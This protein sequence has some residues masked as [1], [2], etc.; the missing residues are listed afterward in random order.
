MRQGHVLASLPKSRN[1]HYKSCWIFWYLNRY[2]LKLTAVSFDFDRIISMR[3]WDLLYH[4]NV[5]T[6]AEIAKEVLDS[7]QAP[8]LHSP[9][10]LPSEEQR[11]W[12][13]YVHEESPFLLLQIK[14]Y[15]NSTLNS[16][17]QRT[18]QTKKM[19]ATISKTPTIHQDN[20][21]MHFTPL[22]CH[23]DN[24]V[25]PC[26]QPHHCS[27]QSVQWLHSPCR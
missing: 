12:W 26:R 25:L 4:G 3:L 7:F 21:Q 15:E 22:H 11:I 23:Q 10:H 16:S 24:P 2:F 5:L 9:H 13:I 8:D 20:G 18:I 1:R 27:S 17:K 14:S 19:N 6:T